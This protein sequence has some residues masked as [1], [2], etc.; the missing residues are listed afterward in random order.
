MLNNYFEYLFSDLLSYYFKKNSS[1]LGGKKITLSLEELKKYSSINEAHEDLIY[2][3]VESLLLELNFEELKSYFKEK[4]KIGL[5][6]ELINWSFINEIRERRHII[7]HNNS[8]VN[9]KYLVRTNNPFSLRLNKEAL[10]DNKYFLSAFN[11]IKVAGVLLCL[12]CW[13]NWDKDQ[14]T[15][16][17]EEIMDISFQNLKQDNYD[18]VN[19]ICMYTEKNIRSRNDDE[20]DCIYRIKFNHC[21]ALKNL[22]QKDELAKKLSAIKIGALSP[23]FKIVHNI[24]KDKD[25]DAVKLLDKAKAVG[26]LSLEQYQDWPIFKSIRANNELNKQAI[27]ILT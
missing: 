19:K 11:E 24:L 10:I 2:K 3:E 25:I 20:D 16:A 13:G 26:D 18:F 15:D 23:I 27:E 12:N 8:I 1:A 5:E 4:L 9:N 21:I 22:G 14:T 17:I 7:V 6:E